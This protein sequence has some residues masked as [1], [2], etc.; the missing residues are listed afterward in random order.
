MFYFDRNPSSDECLEKVR[1][2]SAANW[3]NYTAD[4]PNHSDVH[5]L[6]YPIKVDNEGN[7]SALDEPWNCFPDTTASVIGIKSGY[8]PAKLTT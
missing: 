1:E 6:P 2:V 5:I 3:E 8:L 7:V 4:E